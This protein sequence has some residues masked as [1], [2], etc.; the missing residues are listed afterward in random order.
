VILALTNL[1][2]QRSD[3]VR[4]ILTLATGTAAAQALTILAAPLLTR[5]YRPEDYGVFA[6]FGAVVG[7]GALVAT[8]KYDLAILLPKSDAAAAALVAA[9]MLITVAVSA[10]LMVASWFVCHPVASW[11]GDPLLAPWLQL[12]PLGVVLTNLTIVLG[13]WANRQQAYA[14]LSNSRMSAALAGTAAN[15]ALGYAEW[16]AAGLVCGFLVVQVA[17]LSALVPHSASLLYSLKTETRL[18]T[19]RAEAKRFA[20]FP[21]FSLGAELLNTLSNQ[22]VVLLLPKFFGMAVLGWYAMGQRVIAIPTSLIGGAVGEVFRSQSSRDYAEQGN[23]REI[24]RKT[25]KHLA[26]LGVGP[27]VVLV[28]FAPEMF[29]IAFGESWR[30]AGR[31]TQVMSVMYYLRFVVSPLTHTFLLAGRQKEDLWL[32]VYIVASS[33]GSLALGYTVWGDGVRTLLCFS[34]NFASIYLY[35]LW[36]SYRFAQ[37]VAR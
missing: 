14:V 36:R 7:L 31:I 15:L 30:M 9:T 22:L 29:A 1:F 5:L 6:L 25:L 24:F 11:L 33:V 3:Y 18:E 28:V 4:Q 8:G 23:C 2:R 19:V 35:Y 37:G 12:V 34:L 20:S 27:F 21:M 16:G 10:L 13:V 17:T 32:H 26:L